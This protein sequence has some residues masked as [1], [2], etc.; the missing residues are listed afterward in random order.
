MLIKIFEYVLLWAATCCFN[1]K[2][3]AAR[4]RRWR[5][6]NSYSF[7]WKTTGRKYILTSPA[8]IGLDQ[9]AD[10]CYQQDVCFSGSCFF[11]R[12]KWWVFSEHASYVRASPAFKYVLAKW[13]VIFL[14]YS[15]F[16]DL[17]MWPHVDSAAYFSFNNQVKILSTEGSVGATICFQLD[18]C[19][20][21]YSGISCWCSTH[22]WDKEAWSHYL[23]ARLPALI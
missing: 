22:Y 7:L 8:P 5:D 11:L 6:K 18:D 23:C 3:K 2:S 9:L 14:D 10:R 16:S 13:S 17:E 20:G 15:T 4:W 1:R 19:N 21:L 12:I